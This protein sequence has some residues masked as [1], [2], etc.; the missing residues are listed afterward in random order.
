MDD[1]VISSDIV[2]E[3]AAVIA[4]LAA[5]ADSIPDSEL[6]SILIRT[7]ETVLDSITPKQP[8]STNASITRIK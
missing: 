4:N 6:R 5:T 3:R 8:A 2:V 1:L 7:M